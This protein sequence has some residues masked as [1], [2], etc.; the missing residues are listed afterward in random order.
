[1]G[2]DITDSRLSGDNLQLSWFTVYTQTTLA[3][4]SDTPYGESCLLDT[5]VRYANPASG[6]DAEDEYHGGHTMIDLLS[7]A[8]GIVIGAGVGIGGCLWFVTRRLQRMQNNMVG[9]MGGMM[10]EPATQQDQPDMEAVMSDMVDMMENEDT[11][12]GLDN[13]E[14]GL[15]DDEPGLDDNEVDQKE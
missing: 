10:Q 11:E 3:S 5:G 12:F 14:L 6:V 1:M 7:L 8:I 15:S 9:Q 13:D 2:N 4:I